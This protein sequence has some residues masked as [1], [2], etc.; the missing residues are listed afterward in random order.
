[1][2]RVEWFSESENNTMTATII[3]KGKFKICLK[4]LSVSVDGNRRNFG[5]LQSLLNFCEIPLAEL[6]RERGLL[7]LDPAQQREMLV[8]GHI[9][10]RQGT[11]TWAM[12][13]GGGSYHYEPALR[14]S[15]QTLW[16]PTLAEANSH[17]RK[18]C[19]TPYGDGD[20]G[21][22]CADFSRPNCWVSR[23]YTRNHQAPNA[24]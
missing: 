6:A 23:M 21:T 8:N 14:S 7:A 13:Q 9:L 4:D 15:W 19:K 18:V 3:A 10:T 22:L 17:F 16:F 11:R 5:D 20:N 1:M 2:V 12:P 24:R